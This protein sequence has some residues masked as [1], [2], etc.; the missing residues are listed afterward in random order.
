MVQKPKKAAKKAASLP[1]SEPAAHVYYE[2]I[3]ESMASGIIAF[4]KDGAVLSANSAACNHLGVSVDAIRIGMRIDQLVLPR[5][6][7]SLVRLV[8]QG[9]KDLPR[10]EIVLT[11]ENGHKKEIGLSASLLKGPHPFNGAVFIFVDMTERRTLERAA[12][13]N[14]QL[15]QIGELTA[16]VV[17]ELRNPLSVI[18]GMS[19]LLQRRI[20]ENDPR[21]KNVDT[22]ALEGRHMERSI[23]QFLGFAKPFEL[24]PVRCRPELVVGR[25][26]DLCRAAAAKKNVKITAETAPGLPEMEADPAKLA[27][28]LANIVSNAIDAVSKDG[29]VCISTR[30]DGADIEF[31]VVDNGPGIHL[32][33][34]ENLFKPFFTKKESGTGLGLAICHR[35]V[36][37]H[38]G[39][40]TYGNADSGGARFVLRIPVEKGAPR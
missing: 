30:H 11:D 17:H 35:I 19:E 29:W 24:E 1:S 5:P 25:V 6:F 23:S 16:G 28:A 8:I 34:G 38:C 39:S 33:P 4:D 3:V 20:E 32:K 14:R 18:I 7:L 31:V 37:A 40:V 22:I 9:H 26:T 2:Q 36:T 27:Q 15:A 21:R 12:E 13:L 10:Q